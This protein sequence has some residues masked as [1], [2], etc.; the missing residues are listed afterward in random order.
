MVNWDIQKAKKPSL[1]NILEVPYLLTMPR[2]IF[3]AA[4]HQ[5]YHCKLAKVSKAKKSFLGW[6]KESGHSIT[7]YHLKDNTPLRA[8]KF[9]LACT[10]KGQQIK[11][12]RRRWCL[13]SKVTTWARAMMLHSIIHW[14]GKTRLELWSMAM[15]QAIYLWN[16]P[17]KRA[18][19]MAPVE[20]FTGMKF[21]NY[22]HL[23]WAYV[24]WGCPI[25]P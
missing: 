25:R 20:V 10:T 14:P 18:S 23:Q 11:I 7:H 9:V 4:T 3:I 24:C 22:Y 12:L 21:E 19:H 6:A 8:A 17:L 2:N 5:V 15:D 13:S 16:N 1:S